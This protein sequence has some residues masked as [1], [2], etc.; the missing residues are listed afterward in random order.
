M[1]IFTHV[2]KT[3]VKSNT[4]DLSHDKKFTMKMGELTP[5][6][7]QEVLPGDKWNI[8]TTQLLRLAP[9]IAPIMHQITCYT[10]YFFVPNRILWDGWE[11]FITGGPEGTS[12]PQHPFVQFSTT[13]AASYFNI[14]SLADY[15]GV[16]VQKNAG[17]VAGTLDINALPF[18]AYQKI[19]DDYY[20]DQN[21]ITSTYRK[22]DNGNNSLYYSQQLSMRKRAW[23]HD[24]FT[25][26]LPWTQRGPEA[27]IPLGTTAPIVYDG[28][29]SNLADK[30]R[31]A[32]GSN[33]NN[34][35]NF[36][37]NSSG[38]LQAETKGTSNVSNISIDNSA[39]LLADLSGA[40]AS[41]I[42]DLRRAFKLQEFLEKNARG[43]ARYNESILAHFGVTTSDG[44]LQ[45]PEYL[46]G[47]AT[48][49]TI[50]EVLQTSDSAQDLTPQGNM[51]GH[52]VSLGQ[53]SKVSY[54]SEEH[55]WIIGIMSIMPKTQYMQ[56]L[57]AQ[58]RKFDKF[59]YYF[60]SFAHIG[61]QPIYNTEIYANTPSYEHWDIFGYTPRYAQYKYIPSTVHGEMRTTLDYWHLGRK[62]DT[63]P[64]LNQN[65]IECTP[66]A[67]RVFAVSGQEHFYVH[68]HYKVKAN[69][70]MPYFGKP[71]L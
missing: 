4:F 15:F 49:I 51:A 5:I 30:V 39:H 70:K 58:M 12:D 66:D 36:N 54:R 61:E 67:D 29:L 60:P 42:T 24:Y 46:G 3:N 1:S 28:G 22:L 19:Y 48:P 71:R 47:G 45:R 8:K 34:M 11:D 17:D 57:N 69:R 38:N 55:G 16:P 9:M 7:S 44:R 59:D 33:L 41:T 63:V 6:F 65:F 32:S 31:D 50:S 14:G 25:S 68:Q 53:N 18:N 64:A 21:L 62:F 13:N 20:R 26:A 43:G 40:S 35:D 10:H 23:Q 37:S 56:G 27:T 52:G 2:E